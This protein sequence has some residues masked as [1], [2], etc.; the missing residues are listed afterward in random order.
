MQPGSVLRSLGS[1]P[2]NSDR[3][4]PPMNA[5]DS[6][7]CSRDTQSDR[8]LFVIVDDA[9][10]PRD[11]RSPNKHSDTRRNAVA[12]VM[13]LRLAVPLLSLSLAVVAGCSRSDPPT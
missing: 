4:I 7:E 3:I 5:P 10:V 11:A 12:C 13:L 1:T 9:A 6:D 2:M 8:S